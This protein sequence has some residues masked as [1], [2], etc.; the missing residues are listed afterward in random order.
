MQAWKFYYMSFCIEI[1][2]WKIKVITCRYI[3]YRKHFFRTH[4]VNTLYFL[5]RYWISPRPSIV[6]VVYKRFHTGVHW[7]AYT[8]S[9]FFVILTVISFNPNASGSVA[10]PW[11]FFSFKMKFNCS[12]PRNIMIWPNSFVVRGKEIF[13]I[14]EE[15]TPSKLNLQYFKFF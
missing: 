8:Q 10:T 3:V 4:C 15:D 9:F 11:L 2:Y 12:S 7:K 1:N 6:K 14:R 5:T 13:C